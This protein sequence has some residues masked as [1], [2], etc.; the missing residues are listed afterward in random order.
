[1]LGQACRHVE[2]F[3]KPRTSIAALDVWQR[4]GVR[5]PLCEQPYRKPGGW[6]EGADLYFEHAVPVNDLKMEL[7]RVGAAVDADEV[8]EVLSRAEVA[9]ITRDEEPRLRAV[10]KGQPKGPRGDWR[11]VYEKAGIELAP[12]NP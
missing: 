12:D 4:S 1:M 3:V 9:W 6:K 8:R 2:Y 7:I 5:A 10:L 11:A